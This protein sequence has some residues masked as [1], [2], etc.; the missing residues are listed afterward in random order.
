MTDALRIH[1]AAVEAA[2]AV[3]FE[4][5]PAEQVMAKQR[6]LL[7]ELSAPACA[8]PGR[9][10]ELRDTLRDLDKVQGGLSQVWV[11]HHFISPL[12][13]GHSASMV[14]RLNG[15][16][17]R[18][19]EPEIIRDSERGVF[20]VHLAGFRVNNEPDPTQETMFQLATIR[21]T[22][23]LLDDPALVLEAIADMEPFVKSRLF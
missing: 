5:V 3:F 9:S 22:L 18:A 4:G 23:V 20:G 14:A 1:D 11:D 16:D 19:F 13:A 17:R 7:L 15:E 2:L 12:V 6:E 8:V 21:S 10:A